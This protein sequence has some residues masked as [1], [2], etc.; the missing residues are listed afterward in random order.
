MKNP[1]AG[2][3][4]ITSVLFYDNPRA[5]T[6]FLSRAFGLEVRARAERKGTHPGRL[7]H[8]EL[9]LPGGVVLV[10]QSATKSGDEEAPWRARQRSPDS[11]RGANTQSLCVYVD[12]VDDHCARARAAGAMV[13]CEPQT[14]DH[15]EGRGVDRSYGALD[16]EGHLWWFIERLQG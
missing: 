12:R 7:A 15:G 14:E 5:A 16:N 11:L 6:D 10:D 2:W 8:T 1:P 9:V 13:V 4:R 3:P